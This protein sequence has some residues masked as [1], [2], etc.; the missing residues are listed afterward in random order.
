MS[1]WWQEL[2]Q[3]NRGFYCAAAFCSVFF[4]WQL[5]SAMIGLGESDVDLDTDVDIDTGGIGDAEVDHTYDNFEHGA[6]TDATA[7]VAAFKVL[8]VRSLIAFFTLFTW[9]GALYLNNGAEMGRA[10]TLSTL[11]G[12]AGMGSVAGILYLLRKLT[13][14]GTQ[15]IASCLG[16]R[17]SIYL[18]IPENGS[19]EVRVLVSGILSNVKAKTSDGSALKAGSSVK[20]MRVLDDLTIEVTPVPK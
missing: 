11:W 6:E 5:I 20:V 2:S 14:T 10:M 3:V 4:T 15:Q 7:T 16:S 1:E 17:G 12:L 19:G 8:S 13:D 18:D 9:G